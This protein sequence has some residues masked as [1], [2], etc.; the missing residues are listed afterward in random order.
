MRYQLYYPF[1]YI[2]GGLDNSKEG[3]DSPSIEIGK[4]SP[5]N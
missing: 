4:C 5:I 3:E 2:N 1:G